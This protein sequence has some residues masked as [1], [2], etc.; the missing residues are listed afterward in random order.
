MGGTEKTSMLPASTKN[1]SSGLSTG[2]GVLADRSSTF[3]W[4]GRQKMGWRMRI[5]SESPVCW[6][7]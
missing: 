3:P 5:E 4:S 7:T 6:P 2:K 1:T